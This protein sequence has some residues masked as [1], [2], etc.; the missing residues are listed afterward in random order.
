M[1]GN[2][3][4]RRRD[5][6]NPYTICERDSRYFLSF[7]DGQGIL[8]NLEISADLYS[9]LNQFELDDLAVLNQWDRHIE[10]LVQT[11][12]ALN[13]R[14]LFKIESVEDTVMQN[15]E[16]EQLHRAILKLSE[17]QQRRLKLYYFQGLTYAQIAK[18]ESCSYQA[19]AKSI[20]AAEIALKKILL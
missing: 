13:R 16:Y 19:V 20:T 4:K 12:Q 5:K 2:H 8:H 18:M 11:E 10:H 9:E 17:T 3:P 7:S 14:S 15:L 1:D 6:Y